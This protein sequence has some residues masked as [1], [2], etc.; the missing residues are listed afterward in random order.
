MVIATLA[1]ESENISY[2]GAKYQEYMKRSKRFVP[3]LL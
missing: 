3:F 2:F 1:E